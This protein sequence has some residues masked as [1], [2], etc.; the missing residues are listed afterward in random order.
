MHCAIL[1]CAIMGCRI[2]LACIA[3]SKISTQINVLLLFFG[4]SIFLNDKMANKLSATQNDRYAVTIIYNIFFFGKYLKGLFIRKWISGHPRCR[5]KVCFFIITALDRCIIKKEGLWL[6]IIHPLH[7][8]SFFTE[9]VL[10][11]K[12]K[13]Y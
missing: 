3:H 4:I 10:L 9:V 12:T 8:I 6:L 7:N 11:L 5:C 13:L 1:I 2:K